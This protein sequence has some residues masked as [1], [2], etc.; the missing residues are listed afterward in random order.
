MRGKEKN[1]KAITFMIQSA[2]RARDQKRHA[3]DE[4]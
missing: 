2:H 1:N 4:R 3:R